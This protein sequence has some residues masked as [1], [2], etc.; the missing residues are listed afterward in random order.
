MFNNPLINTIVLGAIA[1]SMVVFLLRIS[2]KRTLS[3][4]NSFDFVV[5]ISFGSILSSILL[6]TKDY[7]GTG[8][9]GFGLLVL[10]QYCLTWITVRSSWVQKLIKAKPTLLLYKG[11]L[12]KDVLRRE[13]VAEGEVLAA[14]R[15]NG[16]G[17]IED[18]D[19]VVLE[20]NGSFSVIRDLSNSS[21]S[22]LKDVREWV[23][24]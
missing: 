3:K 9:L 8:I 18:V 6:S 5:T 19:A 24:D 11:Q 4:W 23:L 1:Y 15:S 13:R 17:A 14:L 7:F 10:F 21:A 22:A 16:V 2:G 12:K 20:I